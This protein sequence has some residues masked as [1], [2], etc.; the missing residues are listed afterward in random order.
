MG[1]GIQH[2]VQ[3]LNVLHLDAGENCCLVDPCKVVQLVQHRLC[4]GRQVDGVRAAVVRAFLTPKIP[5]LAQAIDQPAGRDLPDLQR[6]CDGAL[7]CAGVACD[8]SDQMPLGSRQAA[9][10]GALIES[11]A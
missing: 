4:G 11:Y 5:V 6:F 9:P 10:L 1:Y 3:L 2:S 7:R 8:G